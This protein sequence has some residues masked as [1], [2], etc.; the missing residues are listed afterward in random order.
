MSEDTKIYL[1]GL[2]NILKVEVSTLSILFENLRVRWEGGKLEEK[3]FSKFS[4]KV[5]ETKDLINELINL[6]LGGI[7]E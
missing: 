3:H 5:T 2:L 4:L 7:E 6:I 1:I